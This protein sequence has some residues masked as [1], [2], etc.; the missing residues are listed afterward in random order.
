MHQAL[1]EPMKNVLEFTYLVDV[2][3]CFML[4]L[5]PFWG[6]LEICLVLNHV[7][8]HH[9]L[10]TYVY[11]HDFLTFYSDNFSRLPSHSHLVSPLLMKASIYIHHSPPPIPG[12]ESVGVDASGPATRKTLLPAKGAESEKEGSRAKSAH[13]K[14]D[15]AHQTFFGGTG[16]VIASCVLYSGI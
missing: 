11:S 8:S 16:V 9:T 13:S 14:L 15:P 1:N 12:K 7:Q 2:R 3:H 6:L 10:F 4:F 5:N